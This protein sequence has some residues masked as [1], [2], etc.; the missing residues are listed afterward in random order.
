M[1][2]E[3]RMAATTTVAA[4][5][6]R[7]LMAIFLL[8][9]FAVAAELVL[10]DHYEDAWQFVPLGL[11]SLSLVVLLCHAILRRSAVVRAFQITM[12]LFVIS[13]VAGMLLHSQTK[14]E[15]AREIDPSLSGMTLVR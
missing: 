6:R 14:A 7:L 8:S 12:I 13:G 9:L 11:F 10:L 4:P 3:S 15:F 1:D 5:L 2:N